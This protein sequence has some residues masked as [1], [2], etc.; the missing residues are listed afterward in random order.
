MF[1]I[2]YNKFNSELESVKA[3]EQKYKNGTL[4]TYDAVVDALNKA[5]EAADDQCLKELTEKIG[6]K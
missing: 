4:T 1:I 3:T 5:R 2:D 6:T